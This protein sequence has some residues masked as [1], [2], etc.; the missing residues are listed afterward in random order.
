VHA[1]KV[2]LGSSLT[3]QVGATWIHLYLGMDNM[4]YTSFKVVY[5]HTHIIY[6]YG[7]PQGRIYDGLPSLV[8]SP[9][10]QPQ[11]PEESLCLSSK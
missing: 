9:R 11:S 6:I 2:H 8:A 10:G 7:S 3:D 4:Y 1:L 5:I